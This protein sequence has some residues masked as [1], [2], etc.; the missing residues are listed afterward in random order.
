MIL[1]D[2]PNA[3]VVNNNSIYFTTGLLKYVQN[4]EGLIGVIAHEIG[5]LNNFILIKEKIQ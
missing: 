5:H 1:D 4:T 2:T 3:F